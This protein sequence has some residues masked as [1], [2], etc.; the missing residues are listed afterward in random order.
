MEWEG[1]KNGGEVGIYRDKRKGEEKG[2][3]EED[4]QLFVEKPLVN[5]YLY[6]VFKVQYKCLSKK[7]F[8]FC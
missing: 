8:V 4:E 3:K 5:G 1:R 7:H 6:H 2:R